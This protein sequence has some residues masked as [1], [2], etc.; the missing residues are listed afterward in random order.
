MIR[1]LDATFSELRY[2]V[3]GL[4][5]R[6]GYTA[7]SAGTLGLGIGAT[8]A[9]FAV[10]YAVLL[11]PL[12]YPEADRI[13]EIFHHAPGLNLPDVRSSPGLIARYRQTARTLTHVGGY[14]TRLANITGVGEAERIR[15]VAAT[16]DLF[17]VLATPPALG[18]VFRNDD[19]TRNTELVTILT[20]ATWRTRFGGDPSVI[21]RSVQLD[22]Q[23]AQI[24]GVMP[25]GFT[26]P[27]ADTRMFIPLRI[28]DNAPFG[29]FGMTSLA[30][31][32]PGVTVEHARR[33]VEQLQQ[34]VPEWF[35]D[36]TAEVLAGFRWSVAVQP[37]H[38]RVVRNV[39]STLWMLFATVALVLVVAASNVANVFLVRAEARQREVAVK[40]ALGA[41]RARIAA[42]DFAESLVLASIA[43][44]LALALADASLSLL[45][46]YIPPRLPR[47]QEI[48][49]DAMIV[50]FTVAITMLSAAL[51]ALLPTF[52]A[53]RRSVVAMLRDG[54]RGTTAGRSRHRTRHVLMVTQVAVA[55]VL[56]VGAGLLLKSVTRLA[57][58]D[59]G[60]EA[61][62]LVTVGVSLGRG[63]TRADAIARYGRLF[64]E[65]ARVPGVSAIGAAGALPLGATG[66]TGSSFEIRSRP[67]GENDASLSTM[68]TPVTPG[69]F[70]TLGVP[71]VEGRLPMSSD[72]DQ[73][74]QVAW[75]NKA[76]AR[77]F[78]P[79]DAVGASIRLREEWLE[80][81]GVVGDLRMSGF[82][83]EAQPMVYVP[84][85]NPATRFEMMYAVIRTPGSPA[86]LASSLRAAAARVD[87][88]VPVTIRTA[89][90]IVSV[91]LAQATFTVML[92]TIAAGLGLL[93]GIV[94]LYGAISYIAAQ[95][96][97]EIGMRLALGATPTAVCAMVLRQG[98]TVSLG[99]IIVGLAAAWSLAR[100]VASLLFEVSAYD[101]G[102]YATVVFLVLAVSMLATYVPA[103]KAAGIDPVQ[104][105]REDC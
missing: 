89:E 98:L 53:A 22:G 41:S 91:S 103:R 47:V 17:A 71:L 51:L 54:G 56:L 27:D 49:V 28:D 3:R 74:R 70:E 42:S 69:Y 105:L 62:G 73:R 76:F 99:G 44:V 40:S 64:D 37:W 32:G 36:L 4:A 57:A 38:E 63:V 19:A 30:R 104:A 75:V 45:I 87:G 94:G 23:P 83:E 86:A 72:T 61:D 67:A 65:L 90:D 8:A 101:P 66:L 52:S 6:P 78:L 92:V 33:E 97:A 29:A 100:F 43:G 81:V 20:D 7:L 59:P 31:L 15:V 24:V 60:F 14:E 48:R 50:L 58:V 55:L 9:V 85:T 26:F 21:G 79:T 1:L 35:P 80:I 95:R 12:P 18:R 68:Y 34:R 88:S 39:S 11:R 46:A 82:A 77:E 10:L 2:A 96:T 93:L 25:P 13:V 84:L 16:P 102:T 5:K